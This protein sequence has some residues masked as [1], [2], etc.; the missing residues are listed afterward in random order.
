MVT[1]RDPGWCDTRQRGIRQVKHNFEP[2]NTR[3]TSQHVLPHYPAYCRMSS[4]SLHEMRVWC[5]IFTKHM[6]V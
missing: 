1:M 5:M 4:G 2:Q 6:K 3:K